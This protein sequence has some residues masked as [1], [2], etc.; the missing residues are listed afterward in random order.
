MVSSSGGPNDVDVAVLDWNVIH[1]G[2]DAA[3]I[4]IVTSGR[5]REVVRNVESK[6]LTPCIEEKSA[7]PAVV[8]S[9]FDHH[10]A[11]RERET[12]EDL[13]NLRQGL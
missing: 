9:E 5:Q 10:I 3:K 4:R 13:P 1:V 7:C 2:N 6:D 8:R 12:L 11:R